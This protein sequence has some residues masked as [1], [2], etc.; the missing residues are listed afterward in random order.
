MIIQMISACPLELNEIPSQVT[1]QREYKM[2]K[3][4]KAAAHEHI[5]DLLTKK[6]IVRCSHSDGDFISSVFLCP[7]KNGQSLK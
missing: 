6:A 7:K 4:E 1:P 5:Q 2:S 3:V